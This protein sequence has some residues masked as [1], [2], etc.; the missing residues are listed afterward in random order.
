V[1]GFEGLFESH[2]TVEP[3]DDDERLGALA[4]RHGAKYTRIVLDRGSSP[5]QPMVTIRG[6]GTL[7]E[8]RALTAD[9]TR[10][11]RGAGFP[12]SRAKI[13]AAPD[14]VGIPQTGDLPDGCYFEHHV[15]LVLADDA[16][17]AAVRAVSERHAAHVS[18]NARRVLADGRCERFVTQRCYD[19]GQPEA[20]RRLAA[21]VDEL[22]AAGHR[23]TEIEEEFVVGVADELVT[24][25]VVDASGEDPVTAQSAVGFQVAQGCRSGRGD[26]HGRGHHG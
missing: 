14:N 15:K 5:D 17:M 10:R 8:Q 18:R 19:A 24:V 26:Q 22:S 11:L 25:G 16:G 2:L 12:V 21:L 7:D 9:W 20:R 1:A 23:P 3:T 6:R 4:A 13:E